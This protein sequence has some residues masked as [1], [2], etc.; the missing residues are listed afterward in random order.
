MLLLVCNGNCLLQGRSV[1][2]MLSTAM[3]RN[4]NRECDSTDRDSPMFSLGF[5]NL[6]R[7]CFSS[8]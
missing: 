6:S 8:A 2:T 1:V 5:C 3:M 7:G 4:H